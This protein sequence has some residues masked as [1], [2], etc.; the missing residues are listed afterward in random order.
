MPNWPDWGWFDPFAICLPDCAILPV[1]TASIL[2]G[3]ALAAGAPEPVVWTKMADPDPHY[4]APRQS[5][6]R[7]RPAAK[8]GPRRGAEPDNL[9]GA[10]VNLMKAASDAQDKAFRDYEQKLQRLE[11]MA[12]RVERTADQS[13]SESPQR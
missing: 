5:A 4:V 8:A 10:V 1:M 13:D 3:L 12:E 2:L 6:A 11:D 7:A 9:E